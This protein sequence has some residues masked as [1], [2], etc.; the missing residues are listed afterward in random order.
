MQPSPTPPLRNVT[1]RGSTSY[2]PQRPSSSATPTW[3]STTRPASLT[4]KYTS[5]VQ[6]PTTKSNST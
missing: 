6:A 2:S 1:R 5:K 3:I 4:S